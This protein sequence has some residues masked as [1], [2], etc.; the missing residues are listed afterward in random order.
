MVATEMPYTERRGGGTVLRYAEHP[1]ERGRLTADLRDDLRRDQRHAML[2]CL[3]RLGDLP[4][5]LAMTHIEAWQEGQE[6]WQP[7]RYAMLPREE[8]PVV[9]TLTVRLREVRWYSQRPQE[10]P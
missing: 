8:Q 6:D 3:A 2:D 1:I 5:H 4:L 10:A 9:L 7:E